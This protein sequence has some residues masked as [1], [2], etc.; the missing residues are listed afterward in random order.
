MDDF[1]LVLVISG[2]TALITVLAGLAA[3]RYNISDRLMAGS[4]Q[5]AGGVLVGLI[6]FSLMPNAVREGPGIP[7]IVAFFGG[8]LVFALINHFA[9]RV[10]PTDT[11]DAAAVSTALYIGILIDV[12]IDGVV[13][14]LGSTLTIAAGVLLAISIGISTAP[15]ALVTVSTAIRQKQSVRFRRVLLLLFAAA[16]MGGSLV[17]FFVF[18]NQSIEI[19]LI[20]VALASGFLITTVTQSIIPEAIHT[21]QSTL[22]PFFFIAGLSLYALLSIVR[23]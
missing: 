13:I 10:D 11:S 3:E 14:G 18:R 16:L 4:L 17:G 2:V 21:V 8:G 1:V 23:G 20:A 9:S 15:L 19:R 12:L 6:A 5:F 7:I 22:T